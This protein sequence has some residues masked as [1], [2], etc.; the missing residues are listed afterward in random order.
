[1]S[2]I[3]FTRPDKITQ[4]LWYWHFSSC[5]DEDTNY[6]KAAFCVSGALL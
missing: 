5:K 6:V 4:V 1:M 3:L 2:N